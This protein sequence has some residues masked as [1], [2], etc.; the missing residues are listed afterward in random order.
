MPFFTDIE[1]SAVFS[2]DKVYRYSLTRMWQNNLPT[3]FVVMLNPSIAD[4]HKDDPTI[5]NVMVF[6]QRHK[7]GSVVIANLHALVSTDPKALLRA[8]DPL[9]PDNKTTLFGI[10]DQAKLEVGSILCAWGANQF[11]SNN[12]DLDFI[13]Y[14]RAHHVRLVC[15]G[16]TKSG[17]PR[18]PLYTPYSQPFEEF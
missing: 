1:R 11:I 14:A 12:I 4:E 8:S 5:R 10:V 13:Q 9:G 7:Y 17:A 3:L 6:A 15:L 16:K 2:P 18:H